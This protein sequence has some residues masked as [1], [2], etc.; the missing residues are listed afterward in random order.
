[1]TESFPDLNL[2]DMI[3][4]EG[5]GNVMNE[6]AATRDSMAREGVGKRG[7]VRMRAPHP[8]WDQYVAK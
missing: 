8:M 2:E 7:S 1:M 3:A 6:N 5:E 4:F